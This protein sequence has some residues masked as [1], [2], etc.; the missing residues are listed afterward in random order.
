[1]A[2][3]LLHGLWLP[4]NGLNLWV[5]QVAGHRIVL[6]SVVPKGTFPSV[7]ENLL[8]ESMFRHRARVDL[9]SPKGRHVRLV[10]PT[11]A[12]GPEKTIEWLEALAYLDQDSPV[13]TKRQREAIAPDLYW[14]IRAYRGL[15]R[16]VKAGRVMIRMVHSEGAW[17]PQWQLATGL[18]E[19]GWIAEME[20]AAPGILKAN[21]P[22]LKE[23]IRDTLTHFIATAMLKGLEERPRPYPWHD[24]AAALIEDRPLRRGGSSLI[25]ALNSW[26]DSITAVD[27]QLVF[28]I[29]APDDDVDVD[30]S[31]VAWPVRLQVRSSTDSPRPIRVRELDV[32][33]VEQLRAAQRRA[34]QV[35]DMVDDLRHPRTKFAY[36]GFNPESEGDWDVYLT[37]SEIVTFISKEVPKL[38]R[39]GFDVM[40]PK[41]WTAQ[42]T[43]AKLVTSSADDAAVAATTSQIGMDQLINYN[44]R[45]SVGD[46][47]LTDE[48]MEELVHSKTGLIRLRGEWVMANTQ[49]LKQVANYMDR[50]QESSQKRKREALEEAAQM[51]ERARKA[52]S[53]DAEEL[54]AE[55]ERLREKY[56]EEYRAFGEVTVAEL[57]EL[58]LESLADEPIEFTGTTW[59]SSLLGDGQATAPE[60]VEIPETVHAELRE[61]QRRGVDW[62]Y[63]MSRNN[64]GCV[65][66]DDM[67]LGKTLQLLTVLEIER[68]REEATGPSLVV[69]PTS[70]V[71]NWAREAAR[72]TPE[73]K[74]IVHH[75]TDRLHGEEHADELAGADVLITSYGV[76]ARDHKE[77]AE[78]DFDHVV[79]DEAQAIKNSTTRASRSVRAMRSR[80]RIA[81]TGTPVENRL[82]EMRSI[83][84]FVNPG[85]LGSAS[86]FRNH[87]ARPIERN[88]NEEMAERLRRLTA[89][90]ILRRLKTDT[91][92]IN[93]LPEKT[94]QIIT[95]EMT[96][97]QAALYKALTDSVQK[98]LKERE[99]IGRKGLVLATI[100]RI[101]QICNHPAHYLADGS[102]VAPRGKHRSGKVAELVRLLD[103]AVENNQRVL[104]FTQYRAF[105]DILKP[106][107]SERYGTDIPFLHGGVSKNARD[108]MVERFQ[109]DDGPLAM[110]LS[111]K[112]GGTG[113][114]LTAAS[115]VIHLDRWWNPAV[116][117]QAT[118]RAFRIGQESNVAVYK[119]ITTG[120][121]EESIQD[122]LD[123][124]TE[125][126]GAVV[127]EG[128]GWITELEPEQLAEL[129]SYRGRESADG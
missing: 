90:F 112:A 57:R 34:I 61:Y 100:T 68:V 8:D 59:H 110:L 46:T 104:I 105:G 1:M 70:V 118:D 120:T 9:Q 113:L 62:M 83:L 4:D 47:E 76:V 20:A 21:N 98:E 15:S 107:L 77:L 79:L 119:M 122:I 35:T 3:H 66:A 26:R 12:L 58:A 106:Y 11:A 13:A 101:K 103:M 56:N 24:F 92:I 7:V 10:I 64:L 44:W 115:M 36:P 88:K 78:F 40:L 69:V 27:L 81:L 37:T 63:W 53:P 116:E 31:E 32:G 95:V 102:A 38:Q 73:L 30:P 94:E 41:A 121:L 87:F 74:I 52:G 43:K 49:S 109:A 123:G 6:P 114:N 25:R 5:E 22:Q 99:G 80:H 42:E 129:M 33:S 39:R 14:L 71:G 17:M 19:R 86:F 89:P 54:A 55:A 97:E 29:E 127:G 85:V 51:A 28:I 50:L 82:T 2:S 65:L 108:K 72:F 67:G 48:E 125:L 60:R 16:F 45:I 111:L 91:T 75:G 117:N 96:A 93:D 124:K 128:E 84:D 23:N 18:S 126:A